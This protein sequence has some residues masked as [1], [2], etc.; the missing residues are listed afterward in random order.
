MGQYLG[1]KKK[2][3]AAMGK[4]SASLFA[5]SSCGRCEA[6]LEALAADDSYMFHWV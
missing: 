5:K 4:P 6:L 3:E 2:L 1:L